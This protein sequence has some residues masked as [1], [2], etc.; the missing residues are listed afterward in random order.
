MSYSATCKALKC[1]ISSE[2]CW[3]S[4][5]NRQKESMSD[6]IFKWKSDGKMRSQKIARSVRWRC[7]LR[8]PAEMTKLD[9]F[10]SL[11]DV[12]AKETTKLH[13]LYQKQPNVQVRC[14][15]WWRISWIHEWISE[16]IAIQHGSHLYCMMILLFQIVVSQWPI[17][18]SKSVDTMLLPEVLKFGKAFSKSW[19]IWKCNN[20]TFL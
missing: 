11:L 16:Q 2:M 19:H 15:A 6:L 3:H 13:H 10:P 12:S 8:A 18:L 4:N 9:P 20:V 1:K 7:V 17:R 5:G 14:Y